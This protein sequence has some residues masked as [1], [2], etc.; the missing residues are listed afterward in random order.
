MI[1]RR[2]ILEITGGIMFMG[3]PF[4]SGLYDKYPSIPLELFT[5]FCFVS[6]FLIIENTWG[7]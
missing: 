3:F 6:G 5:I 1:I 7:R 4:L 2:K